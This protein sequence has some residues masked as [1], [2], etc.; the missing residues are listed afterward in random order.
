MIATMVTKRITQ[1]VTMA[2]APDPKNKLMYVLI[3]LLSA[4]SLAHTTCRTL[5]RVKG[6]HTK[7]LPTLTMMIQTMMRLVNLRIK[8]QRT[9]LRFEL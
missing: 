1:T 4:G 5:E 6:A 9:V 8:I 7:I 3:S 2:K